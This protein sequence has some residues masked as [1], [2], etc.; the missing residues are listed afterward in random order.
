[1]TENTDKKRKRRQSK[2][3]LARVITKISDGELANKC[4]VWAQLL[5]ENLAAFQALDSTFDAAYV[6]NWY[7]A[8]EAFE[9][10]PTNEYMEDLQIESRIVMEQKRAAFGVLLKD[11]EYYVQRAF[12]TR[13]RVEMEFGLH[14]LRTPQA[15]RGHPRCGDRLCYAYAYGLLQRATTGRGHASGISG[16]DGCRPGRLC[17]GGG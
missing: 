6:A 15:A 2:N 17:R 9:V 4:R 3:E 11:L 8:V 14:K 12:P 1:M 10:M 13:K 7:S 16:S 5:N